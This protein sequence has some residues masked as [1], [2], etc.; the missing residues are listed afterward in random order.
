MQIVN[1]STI[2][3]R[4]WCY[5][6]NDGVKLVELARGDVSKNGGKASYNPPSNTTGRYY[7][8]FNKE[9]RGRGPSSTGPLGGGELPASGT[10]V[11][12]GSGPYKVEAT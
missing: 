5:N 4:W 10:I 9:G 8:R 3:A 12:K 2:D 7:V 11:L 1:D 6:S